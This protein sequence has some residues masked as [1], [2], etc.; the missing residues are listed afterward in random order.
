MFNFRE[1]YE[2]TK[3]AYTSFKLNN[4]IAEYMARHGYDHQELGE[5]GPR[6]AIKFIN[7]V[8]QS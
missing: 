4:L 5:L 8:S 7:Y 1:I 6:R 3:H 2:I